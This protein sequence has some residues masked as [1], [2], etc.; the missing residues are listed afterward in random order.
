MS[1]Q[2]GSHPFDPA[3]VDPEE[4][5]LESPRSRRGSQRTWWI[6]G[7]V[8]VLAMSAI[9]AWFGISASE[10]VKFSQAGFKVLSPAEVRVSWD[11]VTPK[12]KPVTCTLIAMNDR[13]D[14]VGTKIVDVPASQFTS[15]RYTNVLKTTQL[16]VTGTVKECHYQ[17]DRAPN[18]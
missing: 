18:Q 11:V 5:S 1:Q 17:G 16:A 4:T 8:G 3:D 2:F 14:V 10:G 15:T 12:K 7:I 6:I 13:R 9:A